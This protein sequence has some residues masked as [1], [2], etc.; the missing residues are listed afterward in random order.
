MAD[1]LNND[2]A[3]R[4]R[5]QLARAVYETTERAAHKIYKAVIVEEFPPG[6][7]VRWA[8]RFGQTKMDGWVK[9]VPTWDWS[10]RVIVRTL[11][12]VDYDLSAAQLEKVTDGVKENGNG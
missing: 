5:T 4:T 12:G 9:E 8:H 6:T 2:G 11:T 7:R 1:I 10:D 3:V